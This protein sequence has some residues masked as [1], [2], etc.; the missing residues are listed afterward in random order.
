MLMRGQ[1]R[2]CVEQNMTEDSFCHVL[3]PSNVSPHYV[4]VDD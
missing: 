1:L 4:L 3:T 2:L